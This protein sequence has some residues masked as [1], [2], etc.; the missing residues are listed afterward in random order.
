MKSNQ[1]TDVKE[2]YLFIFCGPYTSTVDG[3]MHSRHR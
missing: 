3:Q 1:Y 2:K